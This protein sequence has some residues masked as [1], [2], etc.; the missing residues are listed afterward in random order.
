V[1]RLDRLK[2]YFNDLCDMRCDLD[3]LRQALSDP[4][5]RRLV[6]GRSSLSGLSEDTTAAIVLLDCAETKLL[7][8]LPTEEI[9]SP[10]DVAAL[11]GRPTR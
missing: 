10:E 6:D 3:N 11:E 1:Q 5:A 9:M 7:S 8:L 4:E 2:K